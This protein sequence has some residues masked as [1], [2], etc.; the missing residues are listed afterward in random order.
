[1]LCFF[2]DLVALRFDL[3]SLG[4]TD[5]LNHFVTV[6]KIEAMQNIEDVQ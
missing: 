4:N 1:M 2:K 5:L 3:R 6:I